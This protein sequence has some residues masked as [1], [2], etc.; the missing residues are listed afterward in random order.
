MFYEELYAELGKV[1]YLVAAADG[2][3]HPSERASLINFIDEKWKPLEDSSDDFGTDKGNFIGFSFDYQET[4]AQVK[5]LQSFELF[6]KVNRDKFTK[7]L[8]K[9]IL[10]TS[11]AIASSYKGTNKK[12]EEIINQI[13]ALLES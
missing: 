6:Y 10:E 4:E 1:F 11:E 8:K 13:K 7:E 3:I 5:D 12:E 9:N 2:K